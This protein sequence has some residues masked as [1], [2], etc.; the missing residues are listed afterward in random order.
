MNKST[1]RRLLLTFS[2]IFLFLILPCPGTAQISPPQQAAEVG[3]T[4]NT[5]SSVFAGDVDVED[6]RSSVFNWYR[7]RFFGWKPTPVEDIVASPSAALT[8][9]STEKGANYGIGTAVS[10][11]S[12]KKW[13]GKAFGGGG[14]FE[15]EIKFN[16][17][18]VFKGDRQG[19][20]AFW[21][22]AIEHLAN[23]PEE[24]WK[25][26]KRGYVHFIEVDIFEALFN[27]SGVYAAN[28][29]QW[30]GSHKQT[31]APNQFCNK[32]L[33]YK[34]IRKTIPD[35]ADFS[36]FNKYGFLWIPATEET[37]GMAQFFFNDTPIG[38]PATWEMYKDQAPSMRKEPW[39]FGIIDRQHLVLILG[40]GKNQPMTVRAVH[41][42]QKSHNHNWLQ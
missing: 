40:T 31:C 38:K 1:T 42:W 8:I 18:D 30:F 7:G 6:S 3:Y 26:Q 22:M 12:K 39:T 28:I 20:P 15:A 19:W 11:K 14:Y 32:R 4:L 33:P 10:V 16:P 13:V 36:Q 23:L 35:N 37:E 9:T 41:V 27:E 25:E 2:I 29:H 17:N 5:F 24:Q 34:H 21:A